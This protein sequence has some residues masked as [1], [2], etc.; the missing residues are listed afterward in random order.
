MFA[1]LPK[2][3]AYWLGD[4]LGDVVYLCLRSRRRVTQNNLALAFST[5]KTCDE[6]RRLA[7]VIFQ[8]Q[9]RHLMDFSH[10]GCITRQRFD[11]M[12]TVEGLDRVHE[13]LSRQAGLLVI[14][15]HC[16]SWELAP[17]VALH[18]DV[19]M[20]VIVRPLDHP[21][22]NRLVE[23]YR[24]RCGYQ[25][26]PKQHALSASVQALR[27][28]EIVCVLMDQSSLRS[29]GIAVEFFGVPAYTPTG[30][31]LLALRARCPAIMGFIVRQENGR[32][33]IVF[34]PEIPICRTGNMRH[35]IA[36][37]TRLF[38]QGIE[39]HVRRYPEQWFWVHRRWK[40][41]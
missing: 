8:Q 9:G 33:R 22:F 41:R 35:D 34:G 24:Q 2:R 27:R 6:R 39:A 7:R 10:V 37:T 14:S 17:A 1:A 25:I 23:A 40:Q 4:R 21:V 36:E 12:C 13:L 3:L 20:H 15:G 5:E 30:P 29:E 26:I 11:A 18:L 19:P 38:T 28:G 16:G 32:H 31:A